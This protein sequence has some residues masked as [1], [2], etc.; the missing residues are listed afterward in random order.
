MVVFEDSGLMFEFLGSVRTC[1]NL[2]NM[3]SFKRL[4][5]K[6]QETD[7]SRSVHLFTTLHAYCIL[8]VFMVQWLFIVS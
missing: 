8:T 3:R 2:F 7:F 1:T 6:I 5:K 4:D